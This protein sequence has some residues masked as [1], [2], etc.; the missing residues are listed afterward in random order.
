MFY[1]QKESAVKEELVHDI[2]GSQE[3]EVFN[4]GLVDF[5][6][7][8]N[9]GR[10]TL[11]EVGEGFHKWFLTSQ[12]DVFRH[13]MIQPVHERA[14]LGSPP[15]KFTNNPNESSNSVVKYWTGFKECLASICSKATEAC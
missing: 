8:V 3:G 11:P 5:E 4:S 15:M 6:F 7:D 13:H 1:S 2:F 12:A 14:Q 10:L 9:L